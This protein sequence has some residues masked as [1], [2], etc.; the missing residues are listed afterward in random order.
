VIEAFARSFGVILL[1][2][3][4]DRSQVLTIAF[5]ARHP[6]WVVLAGISGATLLP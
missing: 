5:A 4:G 6:W 3:L 1:A 2:E